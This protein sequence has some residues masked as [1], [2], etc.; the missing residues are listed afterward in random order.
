MAEAVKRAILARQHALIE[1]PTGTGKSIAYLAPA[2]LSGK[3]VVVSTANKSLQSQLCRRKSPFC[4]RCWDADPRR[5]RQ[6]AQ[7]LCLHATSGRKSWRAE[8]HLAL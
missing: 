7:Q 3:T 2:I 1:A 4:A 6:G 8:V 5:R